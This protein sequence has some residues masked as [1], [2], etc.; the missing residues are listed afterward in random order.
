MASSIVTSR[1]AVT[2]VSSSLTGLRDYSRWWTLIL[3]HKASSFLI[4]AAFIMSKEWKRCVKN[5]KPDMLSHTAYLPS[6]VKLVYLP[7]YSPDLNPIEECFSFVKHYIRRHRQTFWNIIELGDAASPF[8]F[9][10]GALD[11]VN[12]ELSE[13]WFHHSGYL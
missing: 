10:Y 3:Y 2:M 12:A 5:G 13:A 7:P 6:G 9:L 8:S 4:T 1:L 11:N